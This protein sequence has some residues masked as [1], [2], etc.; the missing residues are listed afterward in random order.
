MLVRLF[1]FILFL[2][3]LDYYLFSSISSLFNRS[4]L[5]K[6]IFSTFYWFLSFAIYF[7]IYYVFIN[8]EKRTPSVH[9]NN[10][11]IIST[12][13]F[14]ILFSKLLAL[15]PLII[16]D[17]LRFLRFVFSLFSNRGSSFVGVKISRFDFLQK[18][19]VFLGST[20]F[21]TLLS[22]VLFGRYNFKVKKTKIKIKNWNS[23]INGLKIVQISDLHLGS[24]NSI[25]KL[26]EV[27]EIINEQKPDIFVFTGD[28]VNNYFTEAVPY[29]NT[30]GKIKAKYG[31]GISIAANNLQPDIINKLC[32]MP[33]VA[34]LNIDNYKVLLCHGSPWDLEFYLYPDAK[35]QTVDKMFRHDPDFNILVYGHTHYPVIWE[36][37]KKVIINPG[38][39][40]QPRDHNISASWAIWD[41]TKNDVNFF[42]EQY[43]A[44][45]VI[46][47][48]KKYDPKINYLINVLM[49]E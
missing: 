22:G 18:L 11:I 46:E 21:V 23:I 12:L 9:F 17:C 40:G 4:I 47:M 38:S 15:F 35:Q 29:I 7:I 19:S 34:K 31:S 20:L 14:M 27:V 49:R 33:N 44:N 28:L 2:L 1:F 10:D 13:I 32:E 5:S 16:D 45:P 39:V 41:T 25:E 48:C 37:D 24:F 30:L 3:F 42:R 8:Y 36:Q 43:D 6:R 26:E